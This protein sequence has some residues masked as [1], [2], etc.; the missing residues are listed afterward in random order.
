MTM[1]RDAEEPPIYIEMALNMNVYG[2]KSE[3]TIW[4]CVGMYLCLPVN[5]CV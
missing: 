2:I 5:V 4:D 3:S 1:S